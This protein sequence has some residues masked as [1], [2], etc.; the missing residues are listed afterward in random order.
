VPPDQIQALG[1]RRRPD[2]LSN[3]PARSEWYE[4]KPASIAGAVA[5]WKK[6]NSIPGDYQRLGLPYVPGTLY[7]PTPEIELINLIGDQGEAL[8]VI[9]HVWR[10]APGLIFYELCVKGDYVA[11]FNRVRLVAGILAILVAIPELIPAAEEGV[12]IGAAIRSLAQGLG[13]VLPVL[14]R[15]P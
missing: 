12:A 15:A 6:L 13:A 11:Y 9:L 10:R 2:I 3:R 4:I 14:V 1:G 7:E 8:D 5:A